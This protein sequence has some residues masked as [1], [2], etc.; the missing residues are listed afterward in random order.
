MGPTKPGDP[1]ELE[2]FAE[3]QHKEAVA[4]CYNLELIEPVEEDGKFYLKAQAPMEVQDRKTMA[5]K[6]A[7]LKKLETA[8][9]PAGPSLDE[10]CAQ[11][12]EAMKS[13]TEGLPCLKLVPETV[14]L[15]SLT[16]GETELYVAA[17]GKDLT[18]TVSGVGTNMNPVPIRT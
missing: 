11:L 13:G 5:E 15:D 18:M 3:V 9:V 7:K 12:V 4:L 16:I 1:A 17:P 14:Q 10:A 6:A 8:Y 2:D